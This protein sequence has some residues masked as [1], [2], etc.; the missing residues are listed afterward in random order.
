MFL[1]VF[2][3]LYGAIQAYVMHK[4]MEAFGW[5]GRQRRAAWAWAGFMTLAPLLLWPLE[6]CDCRLLVGALAALVYGWMGASFLFFWLALAVDVWR[7]PARV[8]H[9]PHPSPRHAFLAVAVAVAALS[10]LGIYEAL[11]PRVERLT[12]VTDK[13][14]AD[15]GPLRIV[16]ISDVH[17]GVT[18][19]PRRLPTI[20]EPIQALA[21]DILL[22]TGDL[23]DGSAVH[24]QGAA[25]RF[26]EIHPRYGKY[27]VLGNHEQ[28]R[29]LGLSLAFHQQAGFRVLRGEAVEVVP[30]LVIAG[31]DDPGRGGPGVV[32][33]DGSDTTDDGA[34]LSRLP[35][36]KFVIFLKHQ[37]IPPRQGAERVALQLSGHTHG[38][39]IFPFYWLTRLRYDFGPGL[40]ALPTGGRLYLSRGT[41]T[42]GPPMRLL[43]PAEITLV[44]L[45]PDRRDHGAGSGTNPAVS[46]DPL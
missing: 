29:G 11:N 23:V 28:Y 20:L 6:H 34:L 2:L 16:L 14:P 8:F 9:L 1:T 42:W 40:H 44:E 5:T 32:S 7:L 25:A 33:P 15:R 24:L 26:A 39:Q 13:L 4:A 30:G 17:L 12:I 35:E 43:A 22:S 37:P 21:P 46:P 41:G 31:V 38:G 3:L 19:G 10:A 27:A 45:V 36:H 18:M